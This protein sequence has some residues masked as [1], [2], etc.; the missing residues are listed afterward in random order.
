MPNSGDDDGYVDFV[1]FVHPEVGGEC[2]GDNPNI[3]SHRWRYSSWP[4]SAGVPYV[5]DDASANGG[6]ILVDDY[7]IQP[8]LA[9]GGQEMI[10]IGV[11]CHEFGHAFDLPDLYDVNGGGAAGLGH[12]CLMAAGNWNDPDRPAHMSA[13]TKRELGWVETVD[14]D[15]Q[16]ATIEL[17]PVETSGRI[18]RLGFRDD[19]WR[20]R[21]DCSLSG[22]ASLAVGLDASASGLRGW[23][24]PKGY[25]N[26][27]TETVVRDFHYDGVG[28]VTLEYDYRID[29]EGGFDFCFVL[30]E[31]DGEESTLAVY[32]GSDWGQATHDL[33]GYFSGPTDYRVKFR[34]RSDTAWSNEDGNFV[35]DCSPFV[36]DG[37]RVDGGGESHFADFEEHVGGWYQPDDPRDNPVS[38]FWLVENRQSV[39]FDENVHGTGLMIYH[40]DQEIIDSSLGNS[41]G[42][43]DLATRGV[44]V[45]E[46]DGLREL[47]AKTDG[48]RG[49]AGDTWPGSTGST[50][51][52]TASSPGALS[53]DGD[54][55]PVAVRDIQVIGDLVRAT[56]VAGEPAPALDGTVPSEALTD[57]GSVTL[58]LAGARNLRPGVAVRLVRSGRAPLVATQVEWTDHDRV[59]ATFEPALSDWGAHDVVVENP[60]GQTAVVAE[61]FTFVPVSTDVPT[62]PAT[63]ERLHLAQNHPNPFNPRTTLRF[64]V[65]RRMPVE[66][67]VFDARGRLV[68][69]LWRETAEA[70]H[71]EV[72][73]DGTDA[74]GA[75]V[76]SGL[77]FARLRGDDVQQTRKMMLAR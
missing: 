56:F 25:G 4:S 42:S 22:E 7:V 15:W 34:F 40:V 59:R 57:V 49:D 53:N 44:V 13:W 28:P 67:A 32:D 46:A 69:V 18:H 14:V 60:D 27:W 39:G 47:V 66:I 68:K 55:T 75:E 12:W 10:Q 58:E 52:D 51:F 72:R 70:G 29:T 63:P 50:V 21:G 1:A 71:H 74:R 17:E 64:E 62:S 65:P 73:W 45:E 54:L 30:V 38:E 24:A 36:I 20:R 5:T 43:D 77:Y 16:G 35:C 31:V 3:W 41:G 8:G 61:G 9:C 11:F 76:S 19:R 2:G 23:A 37:V 48:N 26:G 6:S 33:A